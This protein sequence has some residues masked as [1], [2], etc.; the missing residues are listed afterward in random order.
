[1]YAPFLTW[2][3]LKA[4]M[5]WVGP[6]GGTDGSWALLF[7]LA[8]SLQAKEVEE[9]STQHAGHMGANGCHSQLSCEFSLSIDSINCCSC[10]LRDSSGQGM[11]IGRTSM[12]SVSDKTSPQHGWLAHQP[13]Q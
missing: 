1:M 12:P 11:K 3:G 10:C 4:Q 6:V 8:A 5:R 7:A 13:V 2:S 9:L